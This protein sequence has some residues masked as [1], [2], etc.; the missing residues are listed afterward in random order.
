MFGRMALSCLLFLHFPLSLSH[1]HTLG[2]ASHIIHHWNVNYT[3]TE[4]KQWWHINKLYNWNIEINWIEYSMLMRLYVN[5]F[6]Y[7]TV[8]LIFFLFLLIFFSPFS[9]RFYFISFTQFWFNHELGTISYNVF[10]IFLSA[11][12]IIPTTSSL[13]LKM[14]QIKRSFWYVCVWHTRGLFYFFSFFFFFHL[15]D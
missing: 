1:A 9:H 15:F 12:K 11:M 6:I 7:F 14:I 8:F 2:R 4:Q 5:N 10:N 13:R 3:I